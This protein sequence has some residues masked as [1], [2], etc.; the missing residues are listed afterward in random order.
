MAL[1]RL[2]SATDD[3]SR[4]IAARWARA[5]G[6]IARLRKL[7]TKMNT[8]LHALSEQSAITRIH[9]SY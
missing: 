6:A 3:V 1:K 2:A 5:W 7:P 4:A 9:G 8:L